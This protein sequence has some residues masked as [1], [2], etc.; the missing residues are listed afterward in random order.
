[1]KLG[2]MMDVRHSPECRTAYV[3]FK[4]KLKVYQKAR[5]EFFAARDA[6]NVQKP[7]CPTCKM[8]TP[9]DKDKKS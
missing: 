4:D 3:T 7:N 1:M 8:F 9:D 6:L 5:T 2:A